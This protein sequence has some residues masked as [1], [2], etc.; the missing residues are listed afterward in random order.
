MPHLVGKHRML[1]RKVSRQIMELPDEMRLISKAVGICHFAPAATVR[2][3]VERG[4]KPFD[5]GEQLRADAYATVKEV[6]NAAL[7]QTQSRSQNRYAYALC[8]LGR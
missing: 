6:V 1:R 8:Q 3:R 4:G 5:A 7:R 2:H